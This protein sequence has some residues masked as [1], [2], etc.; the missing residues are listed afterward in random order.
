MNVIVFGSTGPTGKLV[1]ERA[2]AAGHSVTAFARR[3]EAVVMKHA[4]LRIAQGDALDAASVAAAVPGHDAVISCL[5]ARNRSGA[6][7]VPLD[8]DLVAVK[9]IR[10]AMEK[11]G[12]KRLVVL[13]AAPPSSIGKGGGF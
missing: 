8:V 1:V 3:P 11:N 7:K 2:L 10:A 13:G 5:G 4:R 12:L 6:G 9:N